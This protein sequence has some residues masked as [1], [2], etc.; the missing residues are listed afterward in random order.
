MQA[1]NYRQALTDAVSDLVNIRSRVFDILFQLA[2]TGELK[3]WAETVP[4]GESHIFTKE[5]FEGCNDANMQMIVKLLNDIEN[6]VDSLC[7]INKINFPSPETNEEG[8]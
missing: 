8:N 3:E 7:N 5:M 2:V 4:V 6:T 1:N